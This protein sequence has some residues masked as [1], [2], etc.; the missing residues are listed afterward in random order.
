MTRHDD[1]TLSARLAHA[2]PIPACH[3]LNPIQSCVENQSDWLAH[4]E[5]FEPALAIP[6]DNTTEGLVPQNFSPSVTRICSR[7]RH[8]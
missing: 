1:E 3:Q 4:V 5:T 6:L 7:D 2:F 8:L